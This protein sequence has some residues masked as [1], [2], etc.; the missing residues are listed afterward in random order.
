MKLLS[1]SRKYIFVFVTG[2]MIFSLVGCSGSGNGDR[3]IVIP[4]AGSPVVEYPIDYDVFTTVEQEIH[5]IDLTLGGPP[6]TIDPRDVPLYEVFGYSA[7]HE[8]TPGQPYDQVK[9]LAPDIDPAVPVNNGDLLS[10]FAMTDI[11]ICDKESPAQVNWVGWAGPDV[12][13]SSAYSPVILSTTHVLD[14]AVQTV[15][16]LHEKDPYDFGIFLGD[17]IN[18]A[19]Y[20]ELRWYIDVLDGKVITPSSGAHLGA[21][22][23]D[24]QKRYR[25]AGLNSSIPWYQVIGNH[26]QFVMGSYYEYDKTLAA[27]IGTEILNTAM[28]PSSPISY[29]GIRGTGYYMGVVDGSTVYGDIIGAG[30]EAWFTT[31][32]TVAADANR[33]SLLYVSGSFHSTSKNWIDEFFN[34][35]SR[36][37]GHGFNL[38][39]PAQKA[40]DPG[41]ACYSFEPKSDIPIKVIVLDDTCKGGPDDIGDAVYYAGCLDDTRFDWLK[42]E[43]AEGQA[44]DKL[45]IIAAHVPV[46]V[47]H[48]LSSAAPMMYIFTDPF[49]D[50]LGIPLPYS[51]VNDADILTELH[52]YPNL[53]LW[54]SGHRHVNVVTP[55][56]FNSGNLSDTPEK[57]FWEVETA[58]LRDFPQQ[59]RNFKICRNS[60]NNIS[61]YV[62]NVDPAVSTVDTPAAKS[63]SY[64]IGNARVDGDCPID[65]T[66]SQAYNAEL[67]KVLTHDSSLGGIEPQGMQKVIGDLVLP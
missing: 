29:A 12:G 51:V 55:Q 40:A 3:F 6:P 52:K 10:F 26:D 2:I 33:R 45:M 47:N 9:D 20:N 42:A 64:A 61:I 67:V 23:I 21:D 59:F 19:Q 25:A 17:A 16:A 11:H 22:T 65:D 44:N 24:Y 46:S 41:F 62:T 53:I 1:L 57:S 7:W 4:D 32:P 56:P 31:P 38:V 8:V 48:S 49:N 18:N 43:L 5:P 28:G 54:I 30:P 60:D 58:S 35:S 36:P 27:R 50:P 37:V 39:D 15:N 13:Q 66:S 34:T 63:R 14:A